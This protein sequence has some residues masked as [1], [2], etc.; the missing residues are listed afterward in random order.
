MFALTVP[1]HH[2]NRYA[3][4]IGGDDRVHPVGLAGTAEVLERLPGAISA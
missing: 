3:L 1:T 4:G 2:P